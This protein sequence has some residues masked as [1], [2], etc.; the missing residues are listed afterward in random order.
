MSNAIEIT[1]LTVNYKDIVA[2]DSITVSIAKN[3]ITGIIGPNGS[4]KSTLL[5]AVLEIVPKKS[6]SVS[7]FNHSLNLVR[8]R[9]AYVP[10]RESI[11][12]NF[13]ISV[14]QVVEMGRLN[15][16]KWWQKKKQSD[17]EIVQNALAEVQLLDFMDRSIGELSGGQQQR[18]FIARALAQEA[19]LI[20]MDEPFVGIDMASQESI[21]SLIKKLRDTGKTIVIVHHD[22][23]VVAQ[24]FDEVIL[25]NQKL[26]AHGSIQEILTPELIEQVYGVSFFKKV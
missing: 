2:L 6:G 19:E 16:K 23:S 24:H 18:V 12:W 9:I 15:T 11:D 25:L 5:K 22:L 14:S 3:K 7:L 10:Q 21:I 17:Q 8:N 1:D 13:P 20:I 4:G 26:I